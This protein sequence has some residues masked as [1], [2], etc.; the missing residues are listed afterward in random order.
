MKINYF[1]ENMCKAVGL[2]I[3]THGYYAIK[4]IILQDDTMNYR[5]NINKL[6]PYAVCMILMHNTTHYE[7]RLSTT[8]PFKYHALRT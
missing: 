2:S 5:D 1:T 6:V 7:Y 8:H 3:E 4:T